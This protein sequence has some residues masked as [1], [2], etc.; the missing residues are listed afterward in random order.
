MT[1]QHHYSSLQFI[2]LFY[3]DYYISAE[4]SCVHFFKIFDE[5]KVQKNSI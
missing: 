4:N 5:Y 3:I 1:F 2:S